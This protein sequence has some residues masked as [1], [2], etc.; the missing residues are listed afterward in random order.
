MQNKYGGGQLRQMNNIQME[1]CFQDDPSTPG[2][3][4]SLGQRA[5][6]NNQQRQRQNVTLSNESRQLGQFTTRNS[7]S[8]LSSKQQDRL[9][10]IAQN[11]QMRKAI[12]QNSIAQPDGS[13]GNEDLLSNREQQKVRTSIA[14]YQ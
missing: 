14:Q 1:Q 11:I 13:N 8:K 12:H 9:P 7:M 10:Q 6:R 3:R 5:S 2:T 4:K